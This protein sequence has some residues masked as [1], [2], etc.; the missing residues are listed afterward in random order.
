MSASDALT[1]ET[2]LTLADY[3]SPALVIPSLRG[4]DAAAVIHELSAALHYEGRVP[5]L[6]QFY[7]AALNRE[8]L[9]STATDPGWALPHALV[10]SL[11]RPCFA[12]GQCAIP[13]QWI[14]PTRQMVQVVF[15]IAV[16]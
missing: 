12:V 10:K 14:A 6:L 5:D 11:D 3:T 8:Y 7:Q 16:P 9:C 4:Q 2:R 1:A 15:L 13:R